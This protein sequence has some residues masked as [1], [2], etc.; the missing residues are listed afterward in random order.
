MGIQHNKSLNGYTKKIVLTTVILIALIT[1]G[2]LIAM[3]TYDTGKRSV[4]GMYALNSTLGTA[5]GTGIGG[6]V[7]FIKKFMDTRSD[8]QKDEFKLKRMQIRN[9]RY[10]QRQEYKLKKAGK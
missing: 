7:Y 4:I 10:K 2:I 9:E 8:E 1:L 6:L 5:L 3:V